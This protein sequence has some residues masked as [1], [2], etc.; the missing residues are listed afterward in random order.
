MTDAATFAAYQTGRQRSKGVDID[1]RWRATAAWSWVAAYSH[2]T[3]KTEQ[4]EFN[5][6][7]IGK[8]LFNVPERQFRLATRYEFRQGDW[9]GL[10]IGLGLTHQS[11][12]PGNAANSFYTPAFT[13]WDAQIFYSKDR[14]KYGL[15]IAN[16]TNKKFFVPS[17][18]FAG[19]QVTPAAPRTLMLTAQMAF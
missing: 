7:A 11:K 12:S 5:P 8:Q 2:Q 6:A 3:A 14:M 10:S 4:D 1:L 16:L 17:A 19:G 13:V 9:A 15:S 18:Y